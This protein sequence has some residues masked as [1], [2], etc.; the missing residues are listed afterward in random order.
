MELV[1]TTKSG[2]IQG[3]MENGLVKYLGIPFAEP[4]IGELRFKR[5]RPITPWDGVLVAK[6]YK[7]AA[8]QF[9]RGKFLGSEDCL[10]LNVVRPEEGKKLPVFVWIHGGGY[11]TGSACDSLYH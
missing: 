6:Q 5:A 11:M 9:E 8:P 1:V 3:H 10:T 7:D 2:K 4:P